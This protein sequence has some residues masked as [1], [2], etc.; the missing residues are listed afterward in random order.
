MKKVKI[1][2]ICLISL[3]C[4]A[5]CGERTKL[6]SELASVEVTQKLPNP[7][8]ENCNYLSEADAA[9]YIQQISACNMYSEAYNLTKTADYTDKYGDDVKEERIAYYCRQRRAE[10]NEAI[11]EELHNNVYDM[12]KSVE[13]C[14]NISAYLD[15][16]NEDTLAFFDYYDEYVKAEDKNDIA[17]KILKTFHERSN[18]LAF[19]FMAEHKG[20]ILTEAIKRILENAS[21]TDDYNMYIVE[22]NELIKAIN[23][24]Y[25]GLNSENAAMVTQSNTKLIRN[26]LENDNELDS[27]SIDLLMEQLGEVTPNIVF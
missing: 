20:E 26:M 18:I 1:F 22:N 8:V 13:D 5:G 17:C 3:F 11:K 27:K 12:I 23:S 15:R 21:A 10:M 6:K 24:V 25:G 14:Q 9:V 16:V 2:A 19:Q 4:L 7:G